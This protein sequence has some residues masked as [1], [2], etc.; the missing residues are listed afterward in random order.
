MV[1]DKKIGCILGL[2]VL[3]LIA[4]SMHAFAH[5]KLKLDNK[6]PR[7]TSPDPCG[8][9]AGRDDHIRTHLIIS[10]KML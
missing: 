3:K 7:T 2:Y 10:L 8:I 5:I 6:F 9:Q 4:A 1:Y